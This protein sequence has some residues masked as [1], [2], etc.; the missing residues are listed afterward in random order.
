[1][2]CTDVNQTVL[3]VLTERGMD[4]GMADV[5]VGIDGGQNMLKV[6]ITITERNDNE[7]LGRATYSQVIF[8]IYLESYS[9][10]INVQGV[11]V[12]QAK[13]SSVNKL[14]ILGIVPEVPENYHNVKEILSSLNFEVI[15]FT[16]AADI[17]MC[18]SR[19]NLDEK[20]F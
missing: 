1:M 20:S 13:N 10:W 12:K 14:L 4:P 2:F 5:H 19:N 8:S 17:K 15:E 6:G 16:A 11:A 7:E 3:K 18:K 9:I